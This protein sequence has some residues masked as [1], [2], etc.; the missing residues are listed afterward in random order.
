MTLEPH[1]RALPKFNGKQIIN[2]GS[3]RIIGYSRYNDYTLTRW[4]MTADP[5]DIPPPRG[6]FKPSS[7]IEGETL[8]KGRAQV[9][10]AWGQFVFSQRPRMPRTRVV[11]RFPRSIWQS[12]RTNIGKHGIGTAAAEQLRNPDRWEFFEP[13]MQV[14]IIYRPDSAPNE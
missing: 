5:G 12:A 10:S 6:K 9:A 1:F 14:D 8:W 11:H 2:N 13:T 7:R 4:A 3:F